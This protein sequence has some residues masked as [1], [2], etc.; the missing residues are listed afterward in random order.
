LSPTRGLNV[1]KIASNEDI[2]SSDARGCVSMGWPAQKEHPIRASRSGMTRAILL[3]QVP[4]KE[5]HAS[6]VSELAS[7]RYGSSIPPSCISAWLFISSSNS[8]ILLPNA[9]PQL[10][11]VVVD[12]VVLVVGVVAAIVDNI[13]DVVDVVDDDDDDD[14]VAVD[15]PVSVA[16]QHYKERLFP[17]VILLVLLQ[18]ILLL[19][20]Q[21]LLLQHLL[22]VSLLMF[23]IIGPRG[24]A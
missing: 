15:P 13:I 4:V 3:R 12:V 11:V 9:S 10:V 7:Q 18:L 23:L 17:V 1:L 8:R 6:S 22:L 5:V 2:S 24:L 14:V 19:L 21:K 16:T 20:L